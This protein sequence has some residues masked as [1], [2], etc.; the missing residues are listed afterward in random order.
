MTIGTS[1]SYWLFLFLFQIPRE[2]TIQKNRNTGTKRR[3][4]TF[5]KKS[6]EM[7]IFWLPKNYERIKRKEIMDQHGGLD[8]REASAPRRARRNFRR[9]GNGD[10]IFLSLFF[11]SSQSRKYSLEAGILASGTFL[12]R[13][14]C[15][16]QGIHIRERPHT[17]SALSFP[18][19]WKRY[20][21]SHPLPSTSV[22]T[23]NPLIGNR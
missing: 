18:P 10:D 19:Q 17:P 12:A 9:G 5:S 3:S 14:C 4:S 8:P 23:W 22:K 20:V 13:S 21:A 1:T 2:R 11:F 16:W 7:N 15:Y 6:K